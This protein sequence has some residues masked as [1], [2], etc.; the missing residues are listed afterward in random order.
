MDAVADLCVRVSACDPPGLHADVL[1]VPALR[2][3]RP[4]HPRGRAHRRAVRPRRVDRY[5]SRHGVSAAR[6]L[7]HMV[8]LC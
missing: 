4:I 5:T 1:H 8:V 7:V 2:R 6:L 3:C